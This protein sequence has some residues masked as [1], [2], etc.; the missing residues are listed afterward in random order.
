[1]G[2][3]GFNS[4][5]LGVV[6]DRLRELFDAKGHNVNHHCDTILFG[7]SDPASIIMLLPTDIGDVRVFER[8]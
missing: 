4:L 1:M 5:G 7:D 8:P 3:G 2:R 6:G